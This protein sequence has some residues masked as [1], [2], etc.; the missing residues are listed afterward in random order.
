MATNE[1]GY[2]KAGAK[3]ARGIFKQL[4]AEVTG[5]YD[6]YAEGKLDEMV[7]ISHDLGGDVKGA[8]DDTLKK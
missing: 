4:I 8:P 7:S 1:S 3:K 5:D 2:V 6:L